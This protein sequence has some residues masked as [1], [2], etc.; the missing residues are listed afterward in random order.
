MWCDDKNCE[1]M[2]TQFSMKF[3]FVDIIIFPFK[4]QLQDTK[5]FTKFSWEIFLFFSGTAIPFFEG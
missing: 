3:Y 4:T 2:S 5:S 1:E